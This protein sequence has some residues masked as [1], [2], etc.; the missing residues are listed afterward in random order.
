[1][2]QAEVSDCWVKIHLRERRILLFQG[3]RVTQA[4][5]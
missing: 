3:D 1:V 4:I 2:S 5:R